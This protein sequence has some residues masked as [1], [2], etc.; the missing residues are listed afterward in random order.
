MNHKS[1]IEL[2]RF[3]TFNKWRKDLQCYN[4][5]QINNRTIAVLKLSTNGE[6]IFS[7]NASQIN[8]ITIPVLILSTNG[9][10]IFNVNESQINNRTIS[11]LKLSINEEKDIQC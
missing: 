1:T 8:K 2:F 9:E 5:S 10:K 11:V 7:L 3:K 4:E 6:K